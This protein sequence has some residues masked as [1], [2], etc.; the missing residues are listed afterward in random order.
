MS[1]KKLGRAS[2]ERMAMLRGLVT[3]LVEH[4]RIETTTPKAKEVAQQA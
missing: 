4:E 3:A 1:N 2:K